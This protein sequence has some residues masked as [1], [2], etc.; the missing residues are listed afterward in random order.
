[1]STITTATNP[2]KRWWF[3]PSSG[4]T[5]LTGSYTNSGTQNFTPPDSNDWVLVIDEAGAN[6]AAAGGGDWLE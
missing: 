5:T 6:L 1:M 3:N 4:A 2:A